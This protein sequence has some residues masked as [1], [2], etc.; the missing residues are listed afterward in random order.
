MSDNSKKFML[1]HA[2]HG[3]R[4]VAFLV[5]A[6]VSVATTPLLL[7]VDARLGVVGLHGR[8]F[9]QT[10][11]LGMMIG[12]HDRL[13]PRKSSPAVSLCRISEKQHWV[14]QGHPALPC[15]VACATR[16]NTSR[17]PFSFLFSEPFRFPPPPS[18]IVRAVQDF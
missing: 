1:V 4:I 13:L 9:R 5:G 3:V 7:T 6:F 10:A 11:G 14:K 16:G 15:I 12:L 17:F 18:E 8:L 2:M